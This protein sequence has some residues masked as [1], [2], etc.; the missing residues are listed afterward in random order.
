MLLADIAADAGIPPGVL[1][2]VNGLGATAG[3]ALTEHPLVKKVVFTGGTEVGRAISLATAG[4]FA[5][6]TLELGGKSPVLVFDDTPIDTAARGRRSPAS[7][8]PA[9]PAS[10]GAGCSCSAASTTSRRRARRAGRADPDRRPDPAGDLARPGHLRA[11]TDAHPRHV[12]SGI[13]EGARLVT[14]GRAADVPACRAATSRAD[15]AGRRHQRHADRAAGDLRA[16]GRR[17]PLRRRG[18]RGP[19]GQRLALRPGIGHLDPGRRAGAPGRTTTGDGHGLDQRPPPARPSSPGGGLKESG[20][21]REGGWESFHDF[22]HVR[23]ITVRTAADDVD[24]YGGRAT[25]R[26]N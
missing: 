6:A 13:A 5:K 22:T 16:G 23:A 17:H 18:R 14:G 11:G 20:T 3:A 8:A 7:S 15:G 26:L 2:V 24:W 1:N 9:R 19:P 12:Q 10:P 21:G 25:G 4:R